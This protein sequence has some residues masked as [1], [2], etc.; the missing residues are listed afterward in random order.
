LGDVLL[1]PIDELLLL[2][3]GQS[4]PSP[5]LVEKFQKLFASM[6]DEDEVNTHLVNPF[7][8]EPNDR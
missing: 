3:E 6:I 2:K 8:R 1:I 4:D 7:L 5:K